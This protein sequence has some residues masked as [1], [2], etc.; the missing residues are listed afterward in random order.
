MRFFFALLIATSFILSGCAQSYRVLPQEQ[1]IIQ[2]VH[3]MPAKKD[4]IF[5]KAR[6]WFARNLGKSNEALQ[7]QD[8]EEG[9]IAGHIIV[10][11]AIDAGMG[12]M[13]P[14]KV[15]VK[16]EIKDKKYR[17]SFED[18]RFVG[19]SI[20]REVFI[21]REYDSAVSSLQTIEKR[22]FDDMSATG[23]SSF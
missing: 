6:Q 8:K 10:P 20:T 9:I 17:V 1:Q 11:S 13:V 4:E 14:L 23:G 12:F 19:E 18:L 5:S 15:Y 16:L 21:G 2:R 22:L 7:I 3:E